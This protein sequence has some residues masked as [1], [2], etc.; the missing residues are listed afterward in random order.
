MPESTTS[1]QTSHSFSLQHLGGVGLEG[2]EVLTGL[3]LTYLQS[4]IYLAMCQTGETTVKNLAK[5]AD[6]ARQEVSRVAGELQNLGLIMKVISKPTK[7]QPLPLKESTEM[8]LSWR[9][10]KTAMLQEKRERLLKRAESKFRACSELIEPKFAVLPSGEAGIRQVIRILNNTQTSYDGI[11]YFRTFLRLPYQ[12]QEAL[13]NFLS[14]GGKIRII[15]SQTEN[16]SNL[17]QITQHFKKKGFFEAK[18]T[19]RTL[20]APLSMFDRKEFMCT[21]SP[22][23]M[24]NKT[25]QFYSTSP[26]LVGLATHYFEQSWNESDNI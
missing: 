18:K 9:M 19:P 23:N 11:Y 20:L 15:I 16:H 13:G 1:I 4:K 3:G 14:K 7:Y 25:T 8:L 10:Q 26:T 24:P 6:V 17:Q 2:V 12:T 21:P 22:K 5:T